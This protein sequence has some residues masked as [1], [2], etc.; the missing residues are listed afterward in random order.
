MR[1]VG[2]SSASILPA[3][4]IVHA[5][6]FGSKPAHIVVQ[7]PQPPQSN[8]VASTDAPAAVVPWKPGINAAAHVSD[9]NVRLQWQTM[10][11][12]GMPFTACGH[13][14]PRP[15]PSEPGEQPHPAR[16]H[17]H[18]ERAHGG[19]KTAEGSLAPHRSIG[20][21]SSVQW[22]RSRTPGSRSVETGRRCSQCISPAGRASTFQD[23][24]FGSSDCPGEPSSLRDRVDTASTNR[25]HRLSHQ[26]HRGCKRRRACRNQR[27]R[28]RNGLRQP[29]T[30]Q[31]RRSRTACL[32]HRRYLL[33]QRRSRCIRIV[34]GQRT[35]PRHNRHMQCCPYLGLC[36]GHNPRN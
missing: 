23:R 14:I 24:R 30:C 22:G 11:P 15:V 9:C 2:F 21:P 29:T 32:D 4:Q 1:T 31:E 26:R 5:L 7:D 34:K 36:L 33:A 16:A 3:G 6:L 20:P 10:A 13:P 28:Y 8:D 35:C 17:K 18:E 27:C 25:R 12:A 19:P